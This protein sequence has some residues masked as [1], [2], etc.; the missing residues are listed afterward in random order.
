VLHDASVTSVV[1]CIERSEMHH[2][3]TTTKEV[4]FA[5]LN[6]PYMLAFIAKKKVIPHPSGRPDNAPM[7][8]GALITWILWRFRP[9]LW[10]DGVVARLI[11][12]ALRLLEDEDH[13]EWLKESPSNCAWFGGWLGLGEARLDELIHYR[14]CELLNIAC[15]G[16]KPPGFVPARGVRTLDQAIA[17]FARLAERYSNVERLS[18]LRAQKLKRLRDPSVIELEAI[19][20]PPPPPPP[21]PP[22]VVVVVVVVAS[23]FSAAGFSARRIRAPPLPIPN[24]ENSNGLRRLSIGDR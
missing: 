15:K 12:W 6:A 14:A 19:Q 11:G 17:R 2:R 23:I 9:A 13:R 3:A 22:L 21:S 20:H 18:R 5:L 8:F 24:F 4:H 7:T 16:A 10:L 1:G